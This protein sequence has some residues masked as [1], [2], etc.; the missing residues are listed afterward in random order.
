MSEQKINPSAEIS[1]PSLSYTWKQS[2]AEVE[3]FLALPQ[4]C[5]AKDLSVSIK[6]NDIDV[7]F[8]KQ[9]LLHGMLHK[10]IQPADSTWSIDSGCLQM[11]LEK[12]NKMEWW[13]CVLQGDPGID[14][15][16]IEPE[17]SS[18]NDLDPEARGTVEKMMFDQ[19]QKM[20][21]LPSS[22]EL[23]RHEMLEKIKK[24]NPNFDFSNAKFS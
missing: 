10:E 1:H 8:N 11:Y 21:G 9:S 17:T 19:R 7:S 4:G 24:A 3:V 16:L 22:D 12:S 13:S 20:A 15:K 23:K 18:L 6:K 2:L 14:T 5:K